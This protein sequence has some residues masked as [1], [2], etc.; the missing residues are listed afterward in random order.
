MVQRRGKRT[1]E[2]NTLGR[3]PASYWLSFNV[4]IEEEQMGFWR[5]AKIMMTKGLRV[6][7][8]TAE[9]DMDVQR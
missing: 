8:E 9:R 2:G 4:V 6:Y 1:K 5:S 3:S 7:N